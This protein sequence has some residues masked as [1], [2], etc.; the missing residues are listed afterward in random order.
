MTLPNRPTLIEYRDLRFLI[1]EAPNESNLPAYLKEFEKFS[2][3]KVVRVC[4]PTYST[5]LLEQNG[6]KV[7]DMAMV[8]G[9]SPSKSVIKEWRS[10]VKS[11]KGK[12]D[13]LGVH[14]IAGLGRA[15]VLVALSLIDE[16][17]DNLESIQFVRNKRRGA[18]NQKQLNFLKHYSRSNDKCIIC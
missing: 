10:I 4:E 18:I 5:S 8:D 17:M 14:C 13:T 3:K 16:G 7:I 1:F 9:D 15:P 2:V 12:G 6:I 11:M